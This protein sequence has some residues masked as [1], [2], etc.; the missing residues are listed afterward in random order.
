MRPGSAQ[1]VR[2]F[3]SDLEK[4]KDDTPSSNVSSPRSPAVNS[5]KNNVFLQS[6]KGSP[7]S[8]F[9]GGTQFSPKPE[10]SEVNSTNH[11]PETSFFT[12]APSSP[13]PV[14]KNINL[15]KK[16]SLLRNGSARRLHGPRTIGAS[17]NVRP[18]KVVTF[19][20]SAPLVIQYES[21]TPEMSFN[22][23]GESQLAEEDEEEDEEESQSGFLEDDSDNV[24]VIEPNQYGIAI[25]TPPMDVMTPEV[26]RPVAVERST[27]ISRRPLPQ[28]PEHSSGPEVPSPVSTSTSWTAAPVTPDSNH[29]SLFSPTDLHG[30]RYPDDEIPVTTKSSINRQSSLLDSQ[31]KIITLHH[32]KNVEE[33][34]T[35][36]DV[37]RTVSQK[38]RSLVAE[39]NPASSHEQPNALISE[40]HTRA[41]DDSYSHFEFELP[42]EQP[43]ESSYQQHQ[44]FSN[45]AEPYENLQPETY[46]NYEQD[47]YQQ[48][49]SIPVH[50]ARQFEP[51]TAAP[52]AFQPII[53]SEPVESEELSE[54]KIKEEPVDIPPMS[55]TADDIPPANYMHTTQSSHTGEEATLAST[56]TS[57]LEEASYNSETFP[58]DLQ[59]QTTFTGDNSHQQ[60]TATPNASNEINDFS[61]S[62][63]PGSTPLRSPSNDLSGLGLAQVKTESENVVV[64]N[65]N[66]FPISDSPMDFG[67]PNG[68]NFVPGMAQPEPYI[69]IEKDARDPVEEQSPVIKQEP[70]EPARSPH[71][72]SEQVRPLSDYLIDRP[73]SFLQIHSMDSPIKEE[74]NYN[75]RFLSAEDDYPNESADSQTFAKHPPM[76]QSSMSSMNSTIYTP[77]REHAFPRPYVD[78]QYIKPDP[79]GMHQMQISDQM[80]QQLRERYSRASLP[81]DTSSPF[82]NSAPVLSPQQFEDAASQEFEDEEQ[83]TDR[84]DE[85]QLQLD[86]QPEP[87]Q[88]D[89]ESTPVQGYEEEYGFSRNL[90]PVPGFDHRPIHL[91]LHHHP[92]EG[93]EKGDYAAE[94]EE[95]LPVHQH[96]HEHLTAEPEQEEEDTAENEMASPLQGT[97]TMLASGNGARLRV[98][99]SLTPDE[100]SRLSELSGALYRRS[101][102]CTPV[103]KEEPS[104]DI[105]IR[106]EHIMNQISSI[107]VPVLT[108]DFDDI[109]SES[110]SIFGDLDKEFEKMLSKDRPVESPSEGQEEQT[111]THRGYNIRE[112]KEVVYATSD[113]KDSDGVRRV[114]GPIRNLRT[115]LQQE[116]TPK[117]DATTEEK[118]ETETM[119]KRKVSDVL[120][121]DRGR[122]FV[123]VLS[124]KKVLLPGVRE[125]KAKFNMI[126]DNG[127]HSITTPYKPLGDNVM[128]EQE[129]ELIVGTNLEFILTL[130]AKWPKVVAPPRPSSATVSPLQPIPS[131]ASSRMSEKKH[132]HGFGKLFG[133]K[134]KGAGDKVKPPRS[135]VA[136]AQ[137]PAAVPPKDAW[138]DLTAVDGSF[139]RVYVAFSQYENEIYGRAATFEIPCYNEWSK[140]TASGGTSGAKVR[141]EPYQIAVLQVQMMFVPR[142]SKSEAL[143]GSIK[144]A[145]NDLRLAVATQKR[146]EDEAKDKAAA[147]EEEEKKNPAVALTGYLSQLGGDCKYW[148]RRYFKLDGP[149]LTAYS[150]TSHKPRVSINLSKALRVI[151]DKSSLTQ[152]TV[153]VG[154]DTSTTS[155]GRRRRKSAFAEHE[156]A[157]MFVDEGFRVRFANGEII[158]FYADDKAAKHA[159]VQGLNAV[160][161]KQRA[162]KQVDAANRKEEARY[163]K[164]WVQ[165]VLDAPTA[166]QD[167]AG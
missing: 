160:I 163:V 55:V 92:E 123:R 43:S 11:Q 34:P 148:R 161:V 35:R 146:G 12:Q 45:Q 109:V 74:S 58:N 53:K 80:Q 158:D 99:P 48:S 102:E 100:V 97:Q 137:R 151:E 39:W 4:H 167:R 114:S 69:K 32:T 108:F 142:A 82:M 159:W 93:H 122:L 1:K 51:D 5:L 8:P 54:P 144:E 56:Q 68:P 33:S 138:E 162:A 96:V 139:G 141:R 59:T 130:K 164:P 129:F 154:S 111:N 50:G 101:D 91:H 41:P 126:L 165:L 3:W 86:Y 135:P 79:F 85:Q 13:R 115:E 153:V 76:A 143:P 14:N 120:D 136:T 155:S 65:L 166:K 145:L 10:R 19:E 67:T 60:L 61:D 64:P 94:P 47:L 103:I 152:P 57:T 89:Y 30:E 132:G 2:S 127:L 90:S 131:V 98:R 46:E 28:V 104:T 49:E 29:N 95:D 7:R 77:F 6:D 18:K 73:V 25:S 42:S 44:D 71:H 17:P 83:E 87:L 22:A 9:L 27:S 37:T 62:P 147:K 81:K 70:D 36:V 20:Q 75:D 106:D 156:E 84:E 110:D 26:P 124:V 157:F 121:S 113:R 116:E 134:K 66:E 21:L 125:K 128:M 140:T 107:P 78:G 88:L 117:L 16:S 119:Q 105:P 23:S 72:F 52:T 112:T 24:P 40:L 15:T 149:T 31:R 118:K 38:R 150:E 63:I 133:G